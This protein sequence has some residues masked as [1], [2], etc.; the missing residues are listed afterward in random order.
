ML[1]WYVHSGSAGTAGMSKDGLESCFG[2]CHLLVQRIFLDA[3]STCAKVTRISDA[4]DS[5]DKWMQR[6]QL[7]TGELIVREQI[8]MLEE[9]KRK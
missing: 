3:T 1:S 4:I 9:A 5:F 7:K 6:L 2:F 8:R